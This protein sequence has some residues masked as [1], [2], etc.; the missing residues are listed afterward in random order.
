MHELPSNI[1]ETN[2]RSDNYLTKTPKN[3]ICIFF[4]LFFKYVFS[5]FI[6]R[7]FSVFLAKLVLSF[8]SYL[9]CH[10]YSWHF[11]DRFVLSFDN[12]N[13][14]S[15]QA[16]LT[17]H[18]TYDV[19]KTVC[20]KFG[21]PID[22]SNFKVKISQFKKLQFKFLVAFWDLIGKWPLRKRKCQIGTEKYAIKTVKW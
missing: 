22:F 13:N 11:F 3:D 16:T 7:I 9:F 8:I 21:R 18:A 2:N 15:S 12:L 19:L 14:I 17:N 4:L 6:L 1:N 20:E 5:L 10:V